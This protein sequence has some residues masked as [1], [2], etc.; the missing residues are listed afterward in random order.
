MI[1]PLPAQHLCPDVSSPV[2]HS[3]SQIS[4]QK[5]ISASLGSS[6]PLFQAGVYLQP[7]KWSTAGLAPQINSAGNTGIVR[8]FGGHA[9]PQSAC[10]NSKTNLPNLMNHTGIVGFTKQYRVEAQA[11]RKLSKDFILSETNSGARSGS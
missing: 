5:S 10:G 7:P 1:L 3:R 8:T 9:Y 11:A 2:C 6:A 4:W